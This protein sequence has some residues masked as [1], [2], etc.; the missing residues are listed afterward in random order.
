MHGQKRP[1]ATR[2][3]AAGKPPN[4]FAD[5]TG[6]FVNEESANEF[7]NKLEE[8]IVEHSGTMALIGVCC[9]PGKTE[10]HPSWNGIQLFL[11][12]GFSPISY[13]DCLCSNTDPSRLNS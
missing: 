4:G 1:A 11:S 12:C 2:W 5:T 6:Q 3:T 8:G 13:A 9:K 7:Q 10:W